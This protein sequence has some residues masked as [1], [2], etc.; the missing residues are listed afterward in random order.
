MKKTGMEP[1][2]EFWATV[3]Y[4]IAMMRIEWANHRAYQRNM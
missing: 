1:W 4:A 2:V 3:R